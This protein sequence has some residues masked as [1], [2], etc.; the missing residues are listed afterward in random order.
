MLLGIVL[1]IVLASICDL[2]GHC[3]VVCLEHSCGLK[4]RYVDTVDTIDF[5]FFLL[6]FSSDWG[7]LFAQPS[8]DVIFSQLWPDES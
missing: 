5:M 2:L 4:Y 1:L 8:I 3:A 6:S 7:P